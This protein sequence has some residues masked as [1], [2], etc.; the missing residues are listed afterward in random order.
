MLDLCH[1]CPQRHVSSSSWLGLSWPDGS[2]NRPLVKWIRACQNASRRCTSYQWNH[3]LNTWLYC[4]T[5][6]SHLKSLHYV[7]NVEWA[8]NA[9]SLMPKLK[10]WLSVS[11][12]MLDFARETSCQATVL[13]T[14]LIPRH[15]YMPVGSLLHTLRIACIDFLFLWYICSLYLLVLSNIRESVAWQAIAK[16]TQPLIFARSLTNPI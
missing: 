9:L 4:E 13:Y 7:S 5:R 8:S 14:F 12:N 11:T 6:I 2:Y 3:A 15:V 1:F 16:I 10:M